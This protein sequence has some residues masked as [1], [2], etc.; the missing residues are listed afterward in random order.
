MALLKKKDGCDISSDLCQRLNPLIPIE[1]TASGPQTHREI[2]NAFPLIP[3]N[4]GRP[5]RRLAGSGHADIEVFTD[6]NPPPDP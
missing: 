4:N 6:L 3:N 5:E 1:V 2:T